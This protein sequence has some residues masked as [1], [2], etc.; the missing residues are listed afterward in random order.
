MN[1][2]FNYPIIPYLAVFSLISLTFAQSSSETLPSC[3]KTANGNTW[4]LVYSDEFTGAQLNPQAWAI[5]HEAA[6]GKCHG[7]HIQQ[8]SCNTR[9]N[10]QLIDGHLVLLAR[11]EPYN[12]NN[13]TAGGLNSRSTFGM[14]C[15][16]LRASQPAGFHLQSSLHSIHPKDSYWHENGQVDLVQYTSQQAFFRGLHLSE[17]RDQYKWRDMDVGAFVNLHD[18]H[19]YGMEWN[20]TQVCSYRTCADKQ[21]K[22]ALIKYLHFD[23]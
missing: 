13:F 22:A 15:F 23:R 9:D 10:V 16:E 18:F 17:S 21:F 3:V 5:E 6:A 4:K 14:G 19:L 11:H 1:L 7:N 12:E 2:Q 20:E 8:H